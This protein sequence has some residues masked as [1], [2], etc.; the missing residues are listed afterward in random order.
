MRA[1]RL[2]PDVNGRLGLEETQFIAERDG[3]YIAS[4]TETGWPYVQFRG[5]PP[6]FLR[7]LSDDELGFADFRG[8]RQYVTAGN[9]RANNRVSLFLMDY[10]NRRRL[11][12]FGLA[13]LVD[14]D[15]EPALLKRLAVE[16][17]PARIERAVVIKVVAFD[18][19]CPS[20]SRPG[21]A[22]ANLRS[23]SFRRAKLTANATTS[24][25]KQ[26]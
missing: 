1:A 25:P 20:T 7:V 24:N 5:G 15:A 17:Y 2:G 6:G 16:A 3:F 13:R 18:W 22:N 8:N 11:K 26:W 9:M 12:M 19:N 21:S 4:V 10:P 23:V 14:G